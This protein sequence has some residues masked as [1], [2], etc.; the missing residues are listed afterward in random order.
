[1][2][3]WQNRMIRQCEGGREGGMNRMKQTEREGKGIS[4]KRQG[5]G[6]KGRERE[7]ERLKERSV[8]QHMTVLTGDHLFPD[9][10]QSDRA[11]RG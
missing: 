2:I 10:L 1:M 7:S 11:S 8:Y 6:G 3:G 5:E 9:S 4:A